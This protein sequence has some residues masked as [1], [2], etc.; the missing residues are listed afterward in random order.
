MEWKLEAGPKERPSVASTTTF[1]KGT[2]HSF[3]YSPLTAVASAVRRQFVDRSNNRIR[4]ILNLD[5]RTFRR[6][7][8]ASSGRPGHSLRVRRK[9]LAACRLHR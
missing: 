9:L 8:D 6:I 3:Y 5:R 4:E 2:R 1:I 7:D